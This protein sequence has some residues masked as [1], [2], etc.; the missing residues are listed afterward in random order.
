M[1]RL[2]AFAQL[3]LDLWDFASNGGHTAPPPYSVR[4]DLARWL[5]HPSIAGA[6]FCLRCGSELRYRRSERRRSEHADRDAQLRTAR[7]RKCSRGRADHWPE[8][9]HRAVPTGNV[10]P[11]MY[12]PR[13]H[14]PLR[15]PPS[16]SPLR[17]PPPQPTQPSNP[18]NQR[19][20][21]GV[22]GCGGGENGRRRVTT[23]SVG[24]CMAKGFW[25][26]LTHG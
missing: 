24:T 12:L 20:T 4:Y 15:R 13:L 2:N 17:T 21:S 9:R 8:S 23:R 3:E 19:A 5:W 14:R 16:G 18:T 25:R 26:L 7:C 6:I 22:T 11:P 10:A 1:R